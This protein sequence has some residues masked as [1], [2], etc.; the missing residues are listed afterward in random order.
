MRELARQAAKQERLAADFDRAV[1]HAKLEALKEFAYGAGHEINN[2]LA[3]I[4]ARAQT[5]LK[6]ESDPEHR[7]KLAA[8]NTQAFRAHEMIADL[9]LF[10]RPPELK[11]ER[12]E[13]RAFLEEL[14]AAGMT[15]PA[16]RRAKFTYPPPARPPSRRSSGPTAAPWPWRFARS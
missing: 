9:M 12:I 10:A 5:L 2:P 11:P 15:R 4:S 14:R 3:N 1:E 16:A 7:Q 13:L 6:E 8:I